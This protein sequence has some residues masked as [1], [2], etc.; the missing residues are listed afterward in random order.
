MKP[1]EMVLRPAFKLAYL[2]M[3]M[4]LMACLVLLFLP[5]SIFL[6][7]LLVMAVLTSATYFILRDVLLALPHSWHG[8]V[9]GL[10]DEMVMTQRNGERFICEVLP[11]SVVLSYCSVL[12][13]KV[14]DHFWPRSLVL[15]AESA[16]PD[17]LGR[18]RVWLRWGRRSAL[19]M[20]GD[21][22]ALP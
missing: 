19:K 10:R 11:D 9:L 1:T 20:V 17:V 21:D 22:S 3:I 18:W 15:V 6:N 12:R 7:I 8:L 4:T 2:L 16:D 13:L 14:K 5:I